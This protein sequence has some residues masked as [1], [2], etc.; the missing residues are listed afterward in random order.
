V[1]LE[2]EF[3][4]FFSVVNSAGDTEDISV[5]TFFEEDGAGEFNSNFIS[6]EVVRLSF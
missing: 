5:S 2:E 1:L 4:G 3:F 6:L